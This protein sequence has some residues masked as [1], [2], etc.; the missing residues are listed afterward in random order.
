MYMLIVKSCLYGTNMC[1]F[2]NQYGHVHGE[3]GIYGTKMCVCMFNN[4][5]MFIV[6][7]GRCG[8]KLCV[9][10]YNDTHMFIVENIC[11]WRK[12]VCVCIVICTCS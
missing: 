7:T 1:V 11:I 3:N 9:H 12:Y 2:E 10:M 4:M 5:C 8:T 6:K